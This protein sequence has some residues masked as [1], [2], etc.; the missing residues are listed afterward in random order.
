MCTFYSCNKDIFIVLTLFVANMKRITNNF[1]I[2][3]HNFVKNYTIIFW[4]KELKPFTRTEFLRSTM[5]IKSINIILLYLCKLEIRK[6]IKTPKFVTCNNILTNLRFWMHKN[7][8]ENDLKLKL[9]FLSYLHEEC[10][11]IFFALFNRLISFN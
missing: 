8:N 9:T 2:L 10:L 7:L 5:Y 6:A 4:A 1:I 3:L 11:K